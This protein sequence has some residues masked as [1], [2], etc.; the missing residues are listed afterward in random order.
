MFTVDSYRLVER[1]QLQVKALHSSRSGHEEVSR[2]PLVHQSL[3]TCSSRIVQLGKEVVN[4]VM[5]GR[6][7]ELVV[8]KLTGLL[9]TIEGV[10]LGLLLFAVGLDVS[11]HGRVWLRGIFGRPGARE[12]VFARELQ[13]SKHLLDGLLVPIE[14]GGVDWSR[15]RFRLR[16]VQLLVPN[17]LDCC[18]LVVAEMEPALHLAAFFNAFLRGSVFIIVAVHVVE[19]LLRNVAQFEGDLDDLANVGA[20]TPTARLE[21]EVLI[22]FKLC[23][24]ERLH[25]LQICLIESLTHQIQDQ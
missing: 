25:R 21:M 7:P 5:F 3:S 2:H 10:I 8:A 11:N 12:A 19:G 13:L 23:T 17:L 14:A 16:L 4:V 9:F 6:L 15:S 22:V 24:H 1:M 18:N 20:R